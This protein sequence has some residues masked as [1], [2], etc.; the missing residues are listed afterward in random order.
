MIQ[1]FVVN[2]AYPSL[3]Q[4]DLSIVFCFME[5]STLIA[6]SNMKLTF[7]PIERVESGAV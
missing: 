4:N 2:F 3:A 1:N 6:Y 5:V 7:F